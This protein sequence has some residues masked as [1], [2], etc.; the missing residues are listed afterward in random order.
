MLEITRA[1]IDILVQLQKAETDT[2]HIK[3]FLQD[4]EKEKAALE[5][6]LTEFRTAHEKLEIEFDAIRKAC[7]N[8]ELEMK[9]NEERITKSSQNL[10]TLT[11]HKA[12]AAL[13]RE[14]DDNKK[15]RDLL[16]SNYLQTLEEKENLAL[17]L[18]EHAQQLKQLGKQI[19]AEQKKIDKK[20]EADR[21]RLQEYQDQCLSIGEN[22]KPQ[23]FRQFNEIS[24]TSGGIAVVEVKDQLCR[25][26]FMNIP[27]QLYIEV[28]RCKSLILCP[29]CNRILY[30]NSEVE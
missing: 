12:Y 15:R 18:K 14:V 6:K 13:Q 16:E 22:L 4:V 10:K 5:S 17:Q 2:V 20:S 28:R 8:A 19:K 9:M 26:C 7:T 30:Y 23:L 27:P 3:S 1:E 25:G 29:Q 24:E 11:S 21:V